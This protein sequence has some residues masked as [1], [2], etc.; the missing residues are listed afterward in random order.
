MKESITMMCLLQEDQT[1]PLTPLTSTLPPKL[2]YPATTMDQ[3]KW[4]SEPTIK[5]PSLFALKKSNLLLKLPTKIPFFLFGVFCRWMIV[6]AS[7]QRRVWLH[8]RLVWFL[9]IH[10]VLPKLR[11]LLVARSSV[12]LR[13]MVH[14]SFIEFLEMFDIDNMI[15]LKGK[16]LYKAAPQ[17]RVIVLLTFLSLPRLKCK[18]YWPQNHLYW[19]RFVIITVTMIEI[20]L[21]HYVL[22][23]R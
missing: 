10:M 8:L 5:H 9:G 6:F 19:P 16:T 23:S 2:S 4:V 15:C 7:L 14:S 3:V 20:V 18:P 21:L 17:Y 22:E 12:F 13:L 1:P 11:V